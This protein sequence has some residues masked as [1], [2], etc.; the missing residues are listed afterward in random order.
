MVRSGPVIDDYVTKAISARLA[1]KDALKKIRRSKD[2]SPANAVDAAISDQRARISRA[3]H[4]YDEEI[5]EGH[6]LKRV[7]DAAEER[8]RELEAQKAL[9]G[10]SGVLWPILD[11][12]D[13]PGAFRDSSLE[14]RR[15]VIDALATVT[16]FPQPRGR[17]GFDPESV[18]I[19]LRES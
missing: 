15:Q 9:Q 10:R 13:P 18:E 3:Q 2:S 8:I 6:D 14:I 16:V 12:D 11:T 5:I 7:R 1:Q 17:K 4:D 19:A